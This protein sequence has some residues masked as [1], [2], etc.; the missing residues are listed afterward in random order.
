MRLRFTLFF[1]SPVAGSS[2]QPW[3][4]TGQ[5][6][7]GCPGQGGR[8]ILGRRSEAALPHREKLF[9]AVTAQ[10]GAVEAEQRAQG[11]VDR[12][13]QLLDGILRQPVRAAQRLWNDMVDHPHP[14]EILG[15]QAQR[16]RRFL[17]VLTVSPQDR[18]A[19]LGGCLLYT[20]PSP[21]D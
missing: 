21:R 14:Q 7:C 16:F 20:S 13:T 19:A 18:G 10:R 3:P 15:G 1:G 6:P 5:L 11:L 17:G 4:R 12:S 2:A 9:A 8:L